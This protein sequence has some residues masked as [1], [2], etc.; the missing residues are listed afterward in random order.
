MGLSHWS[1]WSWN[2]AG[3]LSRKANTASHSGVSSSQSIT[4]SSAPM[5]FTVP[6]SACQSSVAPGDRAASAASAVA[7]ASSSAG[8]RIG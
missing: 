3:W 4:S 6:R 1:P 7:L 8:Q 5:Y 2:S